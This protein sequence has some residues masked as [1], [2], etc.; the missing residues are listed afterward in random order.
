MPWDAEMGAHLVNWAVARLREAHA[1]VRW[2]DHD[3]DAPMARY[4]CIVFGLLGRFDVYSDVIFYLTLNK[5]ESITWFSIWHHK[6]HLGVELQSI[7]CFVLVVGVFIAQ[8]VPGVHLL[9]TKRIFPMALKFN[10]FSVLLLELEST[11]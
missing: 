5:C 4:R 3:G 1:P 10:D 6:F 11:R 9:Y 2:R 8:A 7:S